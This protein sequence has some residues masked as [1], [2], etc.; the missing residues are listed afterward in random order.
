[1]F[2]LNHSGQPAAAFK[3]GLARIAMLRKTEASLGP[4]H[5]ISVDLREQVACSLLQLGRIEEAARLIDE[6]IEISKQVTPEGYVSQ[7]WQ[8][9][10]LMTGAAIANQVGNSRQG[11]E[12]AKVAVDSFSK[13][14]DLA[15]GLVWITRKLAESYVCLS[16]CLV[17]MEQLD[18][19][20]HALREA[21]RLDQS[22]G[23]KRDRYY[24]ARV[25]FRLAQVL[26]ASGRKQEASQAA[27]SSLQVYEEFEQAL[28]DEP[29][30]ISKLVILLTMSPDASL[31]DADRAGDLATR[32]LPDS[33]GL[34]WRLR[35]LAQYRA[36]QWG[37]A[38]QSAG[39]AM[40]KLEGGDS[41]DRLILAMACCQMTKRGEAQ[42]W[43]AQAIDRV[44]LGK[45]T[46]YH[47]MG[48]LAVHQL[49][50]EAETMIFDNETD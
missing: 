26:A 10:A 20:E 32:R 30:C 50:E 29:D 13:L 11:F 34:Y 44:E 37:D 28:P 46:H 15:P 21:L 17:A 2:S 39:E 5:S 36:G 24:A 9:R 3:L 35:A 40:A 23:K 19:A 25:E 18:E 7:Y 22:I 16:D 49:R 33:C 6:A 42:S 14:H 1:M 31:R 41:I 47:D 4:R 45:P 27:R 8:A 12:R 43:F 48:P 38:I